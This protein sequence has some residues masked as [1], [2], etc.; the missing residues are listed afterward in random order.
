VKGLG[1]GALSLALLVGA[2]PGSAADE[3]MYTHVT[4]RG[5]TLIGLGRRFLIEPSRWPEI[6][7]ANR[8]RHPDLIGTGV[9]ILIPL[10]LMRTEPAPSTV[11]SVTGQAQAAAAPVGPGQSLP[12]GSELQTGTDGHV[13]LRLVDGTVLRLRPDSR[14]TLSESRRIVGTP[15]TRAGAQLRS[16]RVEVEAAPAPAG[17]PGFEISTPQG[18]LGVRG[19]EFRVAA[20]PALTRGEVLAGVV[21][22]DSRAGGAGQ[23][24]GAGFGTVVPAGAP[25]APPVPLLPAPAVDG[26]PT[27]Q[28]RILMRFELPPQPGARAWRGQIARDAGF[29]TVLA[30]LTTE[31]PVLRFA[32][33]PDGD[34]VLRVRAVDAQGLEG[35]D[36]TLR[37]RLKA[38]PEPPLPSAPPQR[39][40]LFGDRVQFAWA[41]TV[42]PVRYRLQLSRDD[43]FGADALLRDLN[44]LAEPAAVVDGLAPGRYHWRLASVRDTPSGVVDQGP[45]GEALAFD[46]R[47]QPPTP[48]APAVG[49][50]SVG[51]AWAGLPGQRFEFQLAR[52]E[53]FQDL[54]TRRLLD[55]PGVELP[56][57]GFGRFYLRLRAIEADGFVGPWGETQFFDLPNC[58]RDSQGQC[59]RAGSGTLNLER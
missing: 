39:S 20:G 2:V 26:L 30:D 59:V 29:D 32:G 5:D 40:Q 19:T 11:L 25:V 13:T 50:S 51:F 28:E 47:P 3:A 41:A 55:Q 53:A 17:R 48:Q 46:L 49:A 43:R 14:L 57:P 35:R 16:G 24:V 42:G 22:V 18:V 54:V 56:R 27:L 21:A 1:A 45:W 9:P 12:E 34:Y 37:F 38:R 52:D 44:D 23:R 10:A 31:A 8:L 36:A 15:S 6:A 7:R 33:L 58:V 4:E